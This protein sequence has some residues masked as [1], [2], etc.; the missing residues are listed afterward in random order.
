MRIGLAWDL[1][2]GRGH[3]VRI[4]ALAARLQDAGHSPCVFARDLRTQRACLRADLRCLPAPH[5]DW[6]PDIGRAPA[7]WGDIL[8]S[9]VGLHDPAQALAIAQGW[10]DLYASLGVEAVLADGAPL[11]LIAARSLDLRATA[12][13][14][15]FL[16]PPPGPPWPLFRDWEAV[17]LS[18]VAALERRLGAHLD[19]IGAALGIADVRGAL[20]GDRQMLFTQAALDH[21]PGRSGAR[22]VGALAGE[23][24]APH[25]PATPRRVF[26][27][28][29]PYYA[30]LEPLR[31]ALAERADAGVLAYF[32]GA[33]CWE[34]DS[35][36]RVTE[37]PV[38]IRCT[39]EQADLVIG[40]GGNL[41]VLAAEAGVPGLWL[42]VQAETFLTARRTGALGIA[43]SVTPPFDPL[44]FATPLAQ[45]LDDP[46]WRQRAGAFAAG[47]RR[48]EDADILD[49]VIAVALAP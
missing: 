33:A 47:L 42:P 19:Q 40:H 31:R 7:N 18:A 8:W 16:V 17:D 4:A 46:A 38:D 23:G 5:N 48:R 9:E 1:G 49:E 37:Q 2:A 6:I 21:Y 35:R 34:S 28:L 13:G 32:G 44:D 14:T 25:W 36:C 30:H 11:A 3:A 24:A 43:R 45:L 29:Q 15:G 41:A 12:I 22:H 26:V 10:R 20:A 39:L 27:Y